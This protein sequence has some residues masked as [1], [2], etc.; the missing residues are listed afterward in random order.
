MAGVILP[1]HTC[2]DDAFELISDRVRADPALARSRRLRIVHGIALMPPHQENAGQPFA[3]AWAEEHG[4]CLTIGVLEGE[5]VIVR[6]P[7][8]AFYERLRVQSSTPYTV[9]QAW[10]ANLRTGHYGPWM[11]AYLPYVNNPQPTTPSW[12][13][14]FRAKR[15]RRLA[16]HVVDA[17]GAVERTGYRNQGEATAAARLMNDASLAGALSAAFATPRNV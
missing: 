5:R 6:Q 3:H 8:D 10:Q 15:V 16:W 13:G 14:P 4:Y 9:H 17:A 12:R 1:T 7:R 2:F 11:E